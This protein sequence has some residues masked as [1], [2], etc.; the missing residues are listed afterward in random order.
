MGPE[1]QYQVMISRA[2]ELQEEAADHRLARQAQAGRK[3]QQR[4]GQRRLRAAFGKL[5]TS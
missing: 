4:S 1:L 5:R 2:A 3:A